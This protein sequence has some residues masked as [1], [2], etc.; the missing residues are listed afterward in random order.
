MLIDEYGY[1]AVVYSLVY[2]VINSI[3]VYN[4]NNPPLEWIWLVCCFLIGPIGLMAFYRIADWVEKKYHTY[5]K[6]KNSE[7]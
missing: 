2:F 1:Y 3:S 6:R 7:L 4:G 5:K